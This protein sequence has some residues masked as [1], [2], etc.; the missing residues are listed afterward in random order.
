MAYVFRR[1]DI[2]LYLGL[3]II[4][5]LFA[6][7]GGWG[8]G[9]YLWDPLTLEVDGIVIESRKESKTKGSGGATHVVCHFRYGYSYQ[10][11]SYTSEIHDFMNGVGGDC[12]GAGNYRRDDPI[13]IYINPDQPQQ[14]IVEKGWTIR[15]LLALLAGLA[16]WWRLHA[17]LNGSWPS[18]SSGSKT[19]A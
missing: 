11:R 19:D 17:L 6:A 3:L 2:G 10:G 8:I 15:H 14:S 18:Y 4:G 12:N 9:V 1:S 16:L 7:W 5:G 13:R